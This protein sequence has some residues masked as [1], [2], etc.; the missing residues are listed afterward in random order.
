MSLN[1]KLL[2]VNNFSNQTTTKHIMSLCA[3]CSIL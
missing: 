3:W 2:A 1:E